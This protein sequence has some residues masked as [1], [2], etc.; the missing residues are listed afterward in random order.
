MRID[1]RAVECRET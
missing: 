1:S